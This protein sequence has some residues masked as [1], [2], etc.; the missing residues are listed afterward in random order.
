MIM[1]EWLNKVIFALT[2]IIMLVGLFGLI[3]PIYPGTV[4]MWLASLGYGV[5]TGFTPLGIGLFVVI[6]LLML[7][8]TI[9]DNLMM[10]AGAR[11]GGASWLTIGVALAAGVIGTIIWPPLGG[12]IAMPLGVL[13]LELIR[14]K[15]IRKAWDSLRGLATGWGISSIIKLGIGFII[16][17]LWWIW[18]WKG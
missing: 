16:M 11:K 5:V 13:L 3:I 12:F 9:V 7:F 2:Q 18:V 17:V 10:G 4:V 1:P 15:D 14:T 8:S 6:T